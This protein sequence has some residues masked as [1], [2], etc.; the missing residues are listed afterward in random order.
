MRKFVFGTG[1]YNVLVG[2]SFLIPGLPSLFG[3]QTPTSDFWVWLPSFF[4]IYFGILLIICSRNLSARGT[5]VI[6]EGILR[7][8]V[9][10]LTLYFG[11]L[12]DVGIMLGFLGIV[13][14]II[15][16]AYF[17]GLPK[18]LDTSLSNLIF[19]FR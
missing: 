4:V 18:M 10:V 19:D 9:F 14:L 2:I 12:G 16:L 11:F 1:V 5:L 8:I 13:D 17:I 6:W 3:I 7:I 15:A